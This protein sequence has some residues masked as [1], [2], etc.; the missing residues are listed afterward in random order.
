MTIIQLVSGIP[1]QGI[2]TLTY[3]LPQIQYRTIYDPTNEVQCCDFGPS[4]TGSIS[5]PTQSSSIPDNIIYYPSNIYLFDAIHGQSF[6]FIEGITPKMS[7]LSPSIS[8]PQFLVFQFNSDTRTG[9]NVTKQSLYF[10]IML[11]INPTYA[12]NAS[13]DILNLYSDI[14]S[15]KTQ[16]YSNSGNFSL[17]EVLSKANIQTIKIKESFNNNNTLYNTFVICET[18][19]TI[20]SSKISLISAQLFSNPASITSY[21]VALGNSGILSVFNVTLSPSTPLTNGK[22]ITVN[23]QSTASTPVSI[24]GLYTTNISDVATNQN[25]Q[26][27]NKLDTAD[28]GLN[29]SE[30]VPGIGTMGP[31]YS[32][33][34]FTIFFLLATA[35]I[36]T[37][38][39]MHMFLMTSVIGF[40]PIVEPASSSGTAGKKFIPKWFYNTMGDNDNTVNMIINILLG[41]IIGMGTKTI[42]DWEGN[43]F[44]YCSDTNV[45]DSFSKIKAKHYINTTAKLTF[46]KLTGCNTGFDQGLS[47]WYFIIVLIFI[48]VG[49]TSTSESK[50]ALYHA[51][52]LFLLTLFFF[53]VPRI[54]TFYAG[55][56]HG[57][58]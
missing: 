30:V 15:T 36:Y 25:I 49:S 24:S 35:L 48:I 45:P 17:G 27:C 32:F 16:K 55:L 1:N 14:V 13:P 8:E 54:K 47:L 41:N 44:D 7:D 23:P 19:F 20:G 51:L 18:P 53:I 10:I 58:T 9:D 56:S 4:S 12:S 21:D 22:K 11:T 2:Q 34:N 39:F 42:Y 57:L 28:S 46:A 50:I 33:I 6:S 37:A 3:N 43:K 40:T 31:A 38:P 52:A 26:T 29:V 5:V